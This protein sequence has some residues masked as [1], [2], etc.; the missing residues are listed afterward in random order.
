MRQEGLLEELKVLADQGLE[1]AKA[2]QDHNV[3]NWS[4]LFNQAVVCVI[5]G[6]YRGAL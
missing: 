2:E 4:V 5:D 1:Q 3:Q 6:R